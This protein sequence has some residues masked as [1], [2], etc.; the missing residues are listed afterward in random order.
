VWRDRLGGTK[1]V[2]RGA[3]IAGPIGTADYDVWKANFGNVLPNLGAA[4]GSALPSAEPLSAAVPEPSTV[5]MLLEGILAM[6]CRRRIAVSQTH[7]AVIHT[8]I[9][10]F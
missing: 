5:M 6:S 10:R 4:S 2:N 8:I 3:G 9:P 1:L 7:A